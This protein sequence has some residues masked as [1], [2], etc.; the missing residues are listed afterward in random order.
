M[1]TTSA[2]KPVDFK[3]LWQQMEPLPVASSAISAMTTAEDGLDEELF[4]IAG[5]SFYGI[6]IKG[7]VP[8]K[9]ASPII[10]PTNFASIRKTKYG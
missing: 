8:Q 9:R 4:Y 7:N 10:T 5:A 1:P 6:D 2:L 3:P